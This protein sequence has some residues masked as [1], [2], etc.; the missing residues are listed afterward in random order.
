MH[1]TV[2]VGNL[3]ATLFEICQSRA[4]LQCI[5]GHVHRH[6]ACSEA[7]QV[8]ETSMT[9]SA[10]LMF[11]SITLFTTMSLLST[12]VSTT[13]HAGENPAESDVAAATA[14]LPGAVLAPT[15]PRRPEPSRIRTRG[16]RGPGWRRRRCGPG[17][18]GRQA[19]YDSFEESDDDAWD[20]LGNAIGAAV[21]GGAAY[22]LGMGMVGNTRSASPVVIGGSYWECETPRA[23]RTGCGLSQP[24]ESTGQPRRRVWHDSCV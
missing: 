23:A 11:R 2:P 21:I 14:T 19:R 17:R 4:S 18:R 5:R 8:R 12:A 13:A 10:S 22:P 9:R 7:S 16:R 15:P 6:A 1:S 24:C 20:S 3:R